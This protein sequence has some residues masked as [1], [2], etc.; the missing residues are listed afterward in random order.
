MPYALTFVDKRQYYQ[1]CN[2]CGKRSCEFCQVPY[3][4]ATSV[5]QMLSKLNIADNNTFFSDDVVKRGKELIV[6]IT[7]HHEIN[8]NLFSYLSTKNRKGGAKR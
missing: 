1:D 2:L 7:W 3:D 8:V 5:Q 6:Q 4:P